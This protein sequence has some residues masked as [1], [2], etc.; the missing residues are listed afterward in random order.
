MNK[1]DSIKSKLDRIG[2]DLNDIASLFPD[3]DGRRDA[4]AYLLK[5]AEHIVEDVSAQLKTRIAMSEVMSIAD[6]Q[7]GGTGDGEFHILR[8]RKAA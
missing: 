3:D 6:R 7:Y 1:L 2:D 8:E 5:R 4:P